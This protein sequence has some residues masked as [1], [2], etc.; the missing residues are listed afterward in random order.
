MP[1]KPQPE[2]PSSQ[3]T[4]SLSQAMDTYNVSYWSEGYFSLN[5]AGEVLVHP[6]LEKEH[7][8]VSLVSIVE[9]IKGQGL[10]LPVLVRFPAIL[11]H[12][13][14]ALGEAFRKAM[15][16]QQYQA[17]YT[18]VYPIKVNQQRRV[19]EEIIAG[20]SE[21]NRV[22]L[23]AG[24][25]PELL[26]VLALSKPGQS[27]IVCNGYKD[28]EFVR[29]A[30]MAE[31]MG[32]QVFIVIEKP[33]ELTLVEQEAE[34]L[35]VSPRVGIRA[36]L[37]SVGKGNWQNTGGEKAKFGLSASQIVS[38]VQRL[39]EQGRAH[40]IEMLHFHMGSQISQV[41]D[42]QKCMG[43]ASRFYVELHQLG[44]H[45]KVV[46]VGGGLGVD[47]EGTHSTSFCSMNY[48][49][50]E[51]A[52]QIVHTLKGA[53]DEA[54]LPYPNIIT[55]SGRALT[56]HH[57]VLITEVIDSESVGQAAPTLPADSDPEVLKDLWRNYQRL[58]QSL[59]SRDI[60]GVYH[61]LNHSLQECQH[62][63]SHGL[64]S[65]TQRSEAENIYYA[66]CSSL[67]RACKPEVKPHRMILDELNEKL[68]IKLFLNF[69]LFQS[70]PDVWGIEQVFPIIPIVGLN[71]PPEVRVSIQDITCDSDGRIDCYVDGVGIESTLP[72]PANTISQATPFGI[73][74]VGAYQ[75]ILGDMHNLF[76]DTHSVNVEFNGQGEVVL[77]NQQFG[78]SVA[79]VL[80]YV[81]FEPEQLLA[82]I[83]N[84][85]DEL[86][87]ETDLKSQLSQDIE[88]GLLGYTYFER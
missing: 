34:R 83:Q 43:E 1:N 23:E 55:E 70:T 27:T 4:W 26:A 66:A 49:Q 9:M 82:L 51:Y 29:L 41:S 2:S 21:T 31:K 61:E 3:A 6:C 5:S 32:H 73:F 71:E 25:K 68:A 52:Y 56:A 64:V 69:S 79:D 87:L 13:V 24:S 57:A 12:R 42:I 53:C 60:V 77:S 8:G 40:W 84:Q 15:T 28:R 59:K 38:L 75:E 39:K 22:G 50:E 81:D 88:E 72:L 46:D 63:F 58:H 85:I 86:A 44:A 45:I 14:Q 78:D 19:V 16:G 47:Y 7:K 20:R 17:T 10:S 65:L 33:N 11:H 54:E 48:S 30:L 62:L 80:R 35:Q 37:S 76:G 18:S 67:R 36:R 74:M